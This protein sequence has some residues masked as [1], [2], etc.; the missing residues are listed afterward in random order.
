MDWLTVLAIVWVLCGVL[1]YG[2][3]LAYF[4]R[5]FELLA[6]ER[7]SIDVI[8]SVLTGIMGPI[9][10]LSTLLVCGFKYGFMWR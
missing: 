6:E 4:Q 8:N 3:N 2:L 10:L 5:R 1:A 9:G 7:H